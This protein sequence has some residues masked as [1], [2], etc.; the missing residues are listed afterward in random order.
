MW[1]IQITSSVSSKQPEVTGQLPEKVLL[2]TLDVVSMYTNTPQEESIDVLCEAHEIRGKF[3]T[4]YAKS[5]LPPFATS[6]SSFQQKI[7]LSLT[8]NFI[9]KKKLRYGEPG[10]AGNMR[11][12]HVQT[13]KKH[14]TTDP[15]IIHWFRYWDDNLL[16]FNGNTSELL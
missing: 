9:D 7:V 13:W 5:Q 2:A 14:N 3:F 1:K 11:H 4:R 15:R 16:F 12:F 10:L 8:V 6:L